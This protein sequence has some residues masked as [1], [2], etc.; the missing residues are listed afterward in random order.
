[1]RAVISSLAIVL[2][3]CSLHAV[4][5]PPAL[6]ADQA[7]PRA[8]GAPG[9]MR[10]APP[11]NSFI[12]LSY[13]EVRDEVRDYP[14][15]YAVSSD[16]LI[17]QFA[18]LRG[19]G[20]TPVSL[21]AIIASR[22]GGKA[23]PPKAVLLTFDDAYLSFY[24]RVFPLLREFNYP[25]VL[26]VVGKWIDAP[27]DG[28]AYGEKGNVVQASFP[29]WAQLREIG[30]SG[31]V[32]FASH[33]YDLHR[34]VLA[35]PQGNMEPAA[36][37]RI[38]DAATGTYETDAQWRE[39]VRADLAR[40]VE[41]IAR[42]TGR[43]PRAMV[44]PYGSYSQELVNVATE[45]GMPVSITLD[46]GINTPQVP[47]TAM[48]RLLI[49]H[50][51]P[52]AEFAGE[53]A[54][55]ILPAPVRVVEVSLDAVVDADPRAQEKKLSALLDRMLAL[56]PT[57]VFLHA[58]SDAPQ[59]A[60]GQA[61]FPNRQVA[62]RAD[63]F[64]RVAW[65]LATRSFVKVFA[66]LPAALAQMPPANAAPMMED[67]A[68]ATAIE[69]LY[70]MPAAPAQAGLDAQLAQASMRL[71]MAARKWRA[72]LALARGITQ[73]EAGTLAPAMIAPGTDLVVLT[74]TRGTV[75][76]QGWPAPATRQPGEPRLVILLDG[77]PGETPDRAGIALAD[78]MRSLQRAG[79]INFGYRED[80]FMQDRP[81]LARIAPALSVRD[82]TFR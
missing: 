57:H 51:P 64:N 10:P 32:E 40:N 23:L 4:A 28:Q 34:G 21:E 63:L 60:L 37:T 74:G 48:R 25:A 52:L 77:E 8:M 18:W 6:N 58:F 54:G 29:S 67:L 45:Q 35:N 3:L 14:D 47:L 68:R 56:A 30:A 5:A 72:P 43:P 7:P 17:G 46:D 65:Q 1:M 61:Y 70:F 2:G 44:W 16:A 59:G 27:P 38:Y 78:R 73:A 71:T 24:T 41:L 82:T 22:Q 79:A 75:L 66:A 31:L 49:V 26:A 42:E 12:V 36:T 20:Y 55:P 69:G 80:D 39:R 19:N 11:P 9:A 76:P 33:S 53:M 81:P 50:N 13:H 62:M 15:P